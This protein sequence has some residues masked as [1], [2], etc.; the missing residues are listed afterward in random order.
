MTR[1]GRIDEERIADLISA[2]PP[3]PAHWVEAAALLPA[4]RRDLERI[5]ALAR[6]D[7]TFRAQ[8]I[9]DLEAAVRR[10]GVDP[11]P[12][13]LDAARERLADL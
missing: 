1:E 4:T 11:T 10:V 3:A 13:L 7:A 2:L 8:A 5:V 9:A 6:E 12:R